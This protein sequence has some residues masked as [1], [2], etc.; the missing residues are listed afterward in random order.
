VATPDE[1]AI[2]A[3]T[4]ELL[5][6]AG[7]KGR[8]P[9]PVDDIVAAAGLSEPH[10]SLLSAS[11]LSE[12]PLHI[13][14]AIRRLTGRVRAVL[15]RT[16]HEVHVDPAISNQGRV[17]FHKLHEVAHE[18]LPWQRAL[19]YADDDATL[20]PATRSLFEW[21]ANIGA[22]GLLFQGEYFE[23]LIRQYPTGMA[24][25]FAVAEIVGASRH[26]T[27]RRFA[28]A[29]EGVITGVVMDLSP[30]SR[31]PLAYHRHE[32]VMSANWGARLGI[33]GWPNVL[34]RQPYAFIDHADAAR[35]SGDIVRTDF[36]LPDLENKMVHLK[37]ELY[38]NQHKLFALIWKPRRE[39]LRRRLVLSAPPPNPRSA[40]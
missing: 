27:F 16:T 6:R 17:A 13:Q 21:E 15:D 28:R 26:A 5:R 12:A 33:R 30:S 29:H 14:R 23:D 40:N 35:R 8:F 1:A 18:I 11:V 10:E 32:V 22:S 7:A 2:D 4:R 38:S 39:V 36:T 3:Y 9:T 19:A 34:C 37:V 20:S 24:T 31:D 25:V